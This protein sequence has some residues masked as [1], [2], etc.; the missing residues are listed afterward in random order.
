MGKIAEEKIEFTISRTSMA[1]GL[2]LF[3]VLPLDSNRLRVNLFK[4]GAKSCRM[5]LYRDGRKIRSFGIPSRINDGMDDV[6]SA[7]LEGENLI[8]RLNGLSYDFTADGE[9][10]VENTAEAITGRDTFGKSGRIRGRFNL[11][12]F[13][14][15]GE[16]RKTIDP[17]DMVLYQMHVRGFTRHHSSGV[18]NPGTFD[19]VREKLPYLKKLGVNALMMLPIY[20]FDETA[21]R[22]G[23]DGKKRVNYW[24]YTGTAFYYAPKASYSSDPLHPGDEFKALVKEIHRQ[25]MNIFLDMFFI[26]QTREFILNCMRYYV[27]NYHID[28]FR[29]TGEGLSITTLREDPILSHVRFFGN[30]W[31]DRPEER[32]KPMLFEMN[33]AFQEVAR[34]YVKSDEGQVESFYRG[35]R[36]ER[37]GIVKVNYVTGHNGFTL[38]DLISYDGKHNEANG[39]RN[40]DGT[41]YNYSWNCGAEGVTRRKPVL[42]LRKKQEKNILAMLLLGLPV[43]MLLAGDEFGN[44]QKGNNNA[45]CQDNTITWLDWGLLEK[46]RDTFDYVRELLELRRSL[47]IYRREELFVGFDRKGL[48]APDISSHGREPWNSSFPFYS[49]QLGILFYGPYLDNKQGTSYYF[50]FNMHWESHDF[51]LPSITKERKWE[52]VLDTAGEERKTEGLNAER[53]A[54]RM[55]PRSVILLSC[56]PDTPVKKRRKKPNDSATGGKHKRVSKTASGGK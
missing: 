18:R 20:D 43:P 32:E 53:T 56:P 27:V 38:R 16:K 36:T 8:S 46:N 45:Y 7:C 54:F 31:E 10:F 51:Y 22:P 50:A 5:N 23:V 40:N 17:A 47:P 4:P 41:D 19:G 26:N 21:L 11:S 42:R 3:G 2:H 55:E 29:L 28:G 13:D 15:S 44:S 25:G 52:V 48:G 39:E 34:R 24:G 35:F 1:S 30:S 33:D 9:T 14:W 49:R 6:F 37:N 12:T